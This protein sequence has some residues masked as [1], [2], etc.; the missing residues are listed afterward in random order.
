M[1][2]NKQRIKFMDDYR[3]E[4]KSRVLN[5]LIEDAHLNYYNGSFSLCSCNEHYKNSAFYYSLQNKFLHF[6][7]WEKA[8][9]ILK[10]NTIRLYNLIAQ[11]DPLEFNYAASQLEIQSEEVN[12]IRNH[13]FILSL[14]E[15]SSLTNSTPWRLYANNTKGVAIRFSVENNLQDWHAFHLSKI[16]YGE[17]KELAKYKEAKK[18]FEEEKGRITSFNLNRFMAFFK[19][20]P[21]KDEREVRLLYYCEQDGFLQQPTDRIKTDLN[22]RQY[23]ELKLLNNCGVMSSLETE[24]CNMEPIIKVDEIILGANF[25]RNG[26]LEL[27]NDIDK[28]IKVSKSSIQYRI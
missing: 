1:T 23:I 19:P 8:I 7:S 28:N 13:L 25:S 16:N 2:S 11:N 10:S 15:P 6:T 9:S 22:D 14:C 26:E 12:E 21:Y 5:H 18:N 24:I 3:A 4:F 20:E 27:L 17:N